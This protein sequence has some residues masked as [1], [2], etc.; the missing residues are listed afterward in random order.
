MKKPAAKPLVQSQNHVGADPKIASAL[1]P[2]MDTRQ[3]ARLLRLAPST[4]AKARLSGTGPC[5]VK[6]GASVRYRRS[7]VERYIAEH[8][9]SSTSQAMQDLGEP[10]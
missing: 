2:L 4:L 9:R 8:T 7:D 10:T 1:D 6:L 3:A 5:F